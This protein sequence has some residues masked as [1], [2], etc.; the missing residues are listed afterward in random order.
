MVL[1]MLEMKE[2][3]SEM[4]LHCINNEDAINSE[5]LYTTCKD[6]MI[7]IMKETSN[8]KC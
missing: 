6:V 8:K 2:L 4:R 5:Y 7:G 3:L 1:L